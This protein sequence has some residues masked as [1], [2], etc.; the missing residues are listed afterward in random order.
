MSEVG[1]AL[2]SFEPRREASELLTFQP[3][4]RDGLSGC[5]TAASELYIYPHS[6]AKPGLLVSLVGFW[7][8]FFDKLSGKSPKIKQLSSKEFLT[9][10]LPSA[11]AHVLSRP[12]LLAKVLRLLGRSSAKARAVGELLP[13]AC[14]NIIIIKK[15]KSQ[16]CV[17]LKSLI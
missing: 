8:F 14:K 13:L 10:R 11:C 1:S 12:S 3:F 9:R 4:A 5:A 15:K 2:G 17:C 16:P 6:Q 7:F